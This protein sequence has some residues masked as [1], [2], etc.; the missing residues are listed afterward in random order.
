[1]FVF[2]AKSVIM[3][4]DC[5]SGTV[6]CLLLSEPASPGLLLS[7]T[8]GSCARSGETAVVLLFASLLWLCHFSLNSQ[9]HPLT[10]PLFSKWQFDTSFF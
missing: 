8:S 9:F 3:M 5:F 10:S 7:Q 2:V 4:E 6:L 1:M